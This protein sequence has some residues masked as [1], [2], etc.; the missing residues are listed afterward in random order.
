MSWLE[1][2][3]LDPALVTI[4]SHTLSHPILSSLSEVEQHT[5]IVESKRL[6]EQRLHREIDFFCYPNGD[7]DVRSDLT[8]RRHYAAAFSSQAAALCAESDPY[9]LPR[10]HAGQSQELFV[11]RLYRHSA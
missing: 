10:I 8:V 7:F 11:R 3:S 6:L 5:E 2:A 9:V 1:A 4:G